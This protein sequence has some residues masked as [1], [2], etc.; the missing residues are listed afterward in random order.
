MLSVFYYTPSYA[1]P[2]TC[3]NEHSFSEYGTVLHVNSVEY[4]PDGRS[5]VKAVG[6]RRFKVVGREMIDGYHSARVQ[7]LFDVR[8]TDPEEIGKGRISKYGC[9]L[10]D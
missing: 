5:L 3:S 8:V 10:Y 1:H 6:E 7:F 2:F 9:M 4:T